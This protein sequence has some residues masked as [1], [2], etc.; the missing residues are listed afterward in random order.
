[1]TDQIV[2]RKRHVAAAV[3]GNALEFYDFTTYAFYAAQ[4]GRAFFPS[5]SPLVSLMLSLATFGAGFVTRP[6]GAIIIGRYADRAGRRPAMMLSFILMGAA[7]L[8]LG[9]CPSYASIGAWA[10]AI[11]VAARL[12]QGFALG[13]EVGPTTSFLLEAAPPHRRGLYTAFQSISQN[14]AALVA[15]IV[16]LVMASVLTGTQMDAYGWRIALLLGA[17]VLPFGLIVRRTL[18]ETLHVHDPIAHD[19]QA[20]TALTGGQLR[21]ILCSIAILCGGTVAT[22]TQSYLTT[23]T[24]VILN[25]KVN[26]A[27]GAT[28]TYGITGIISNVFGA[29]LSERFGR[30]VV[31]IAPRIVLA[32]AIVPAFALLARNRDA[33]TLVGMTA[34]MTLCASTSGGAMMAAIAESLKKTNRASTF[35]II[36]AGPIVVFGG[37]TQLFV[38]WLIH[39]TGSV[40]AP[41]YFYLTATLVSLVG[42]FA[43][44]E[45]APA[46]IRTPALTQNGT[47]PRS[48]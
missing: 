35:S 15:G 4:I 47:V 20:H 42:M 28:V 16:G 14:F 29:Q 32:L 1:M 24:S 9:L 33:T 19:A 30:R 31:M 18:P 13:G 46:Q 5:T 26:I 25:M 21:V 22:Y 48:G 27:F 2:V 3:A 40:L 37:S 12:I 45:S 23:Y 41:A 38:T 6:L 36:Y 7:L 10:S 43:L 11:V 34:F 39:Q 17:I 8:I 44:R